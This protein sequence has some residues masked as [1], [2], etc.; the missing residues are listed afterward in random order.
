VA[1]A[2]LKPVFPALWPSLRAVW[3]LLGLT[4]LLALASV[5][6]PLVY[7]VAVGCVA[8][9]ALFIVDAV[10][11]PSP[12]TLRVARRELPRLALRRPAAA[13][14][15]VENRAAL[16]VRLGI[17]E[18]PVPLLRFAAPTCEAVVPARMRAT[19]ELPFVPI[20][21]GTA[22]FGALYVWVENRIGLL[23]RR[24]RVDAAAQTRVFPDLSAALGYGTLAKRS[25]QLAAGLRRLRLRGAG[26]E[27]ESLRD[28]QP[29]D[30]FRL[31]DWKATARRGRMMVAQY[32][33]ER[34]QNVILALD[35]GRLMTPRLGLERKFDYALTAALCVAR[36]AQAAGDN[37]GL[38]AFAAAPLISIP[39]R[40]GAAHVAALARATFDLQPRLEESDYETT[41]ASLRRRYSKRSLIVLF[42]D[43]FDPVTSA[44]VLAGL[45]TLVPR[46]LVLCVLMN[47][48]AISEALERVPQAPADAYRTAVAMTLADER[49]RAIGTLRA[50]GII[51]VDVAASKLTLALLDAYL[52]VKARGS[53]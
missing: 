10:L 6:P 51:V 9:A 1:R 53:L 48:A 23:R 16:A 17:F 3:V 42:T 37:I 46:H 35:C 13:M 38:V 27:F 22:R 43:I 4:V 30:A 50:R 11:G 12:R 32:E 15:E 25:T 18:T 41:F 5:V 26:N 20:E 29:G 24:Y 47:D 33:V 45:A 8:T 28:Y 40:R 36:V 21:R 44:A 39:A 49:A 14:Y 31:V 52:D 7:A 19:L 34:S 2:A